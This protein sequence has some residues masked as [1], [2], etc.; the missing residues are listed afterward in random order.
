MFAQSDDKVR[1]SYMEHGTVYFWTATLNGWNR[2]LE[3]D[4]Y[5][6]EIIA[7]LR[8]LSELGKI[9]V[10]GFVIMSHSSARLRRGLAREHLV[11]IMLSKRFD[12][13]QQP[14]A[15]TLISLY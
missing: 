1:K 11:P 12:Y 7:S 9:Q 6:D 15:A 4:R 2:L 13:A 5:K 8:R 10:F 3:E 14:E